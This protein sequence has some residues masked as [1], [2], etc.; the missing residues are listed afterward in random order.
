LGAGHI[1]G[2]RAQ[3]SLPGD[4]GQIRGE[5]TTG[6][7]NSSKL[8]FDIDTVEYHNWQGGGGFGDPLDRE[9][10]RVLADVRAGL[11]SA[12]EARRVYGVVLTGDGPDRVDAAGTESTRERIRRERLARARPYQEQHP[13]VIP[14]PPA[15]PPAGGVMYWDL[16]AI[17]H[18]AGVA[19]CQ[20][21][22]HVLTDART[23]VRQGCVVEE[24][25]PSHAGPV[26]GELYVGEDERPVV[27]RLF[28]CPSCG[29]QLEA[30]L[31][32]PGQPGP[33]AVILSAPE[34]GASDE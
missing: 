11:V 3:P 12:T 9:P 4:L 18:A 20:R 25:A 24:L 14:D 13:L 5:L 1:A 19:R 10:E 8:R 16:V 26:R 7:L 15:D 34:G 6:E 32:I 33:S 23:D 22:D 27:L 31:V 21:C 30:D 28:Y 17:D 2:H 29:R